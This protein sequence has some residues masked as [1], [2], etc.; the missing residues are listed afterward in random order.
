MHKELESAMQMRVLKAV[1]Y[2]K[3]YYFIWSTL[4]DV[5]KCKRAVLNGPFL[6]TLHAKAGIERGEN[7]TFC[8]HQYDKYAW[9]KI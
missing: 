6:G 8:E 4:A 2:G 1:R 7:I 9:L 3:Y 5:S